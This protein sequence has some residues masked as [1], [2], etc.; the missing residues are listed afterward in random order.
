MVGHSGPMKLGSGVGL[1][2]AELFG[3]PSL[4]RGALHQSIRRNLLLRVKV[5]W[6]AFASS[7]LDHFH[8]LALMT[9]SDCG[10]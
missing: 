7:P 1:R 3:C 4:Q 10:Y 9:H 5:D 2:Q 8:A 6:R